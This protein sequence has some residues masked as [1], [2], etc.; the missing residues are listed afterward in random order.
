MPV[1]SAMLCPTPHKWKWSVD[2]PQG[3]APLRELDAPA[4]VS[5]Y[6]VGSLTPL[7]MGSPYPGSSSPQEGLDI[8]RLFLSLPGC[9]PCPVFISPFS[10]RPCL[11]ALLL[12]CP[13]SPAPQGGKE[14]LPPACL[15]NRPALLGLLRF[16]DLPFLRPG[17][18]PP[19]FFPDTAHLWHRHS[20]CK[21]SCQVW[22]TGGAW[23]VGRR[24]KGLQG[25]APCDR[26][27][28]A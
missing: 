19:L 3:R 23:G 8:F 22:G 16:R 26:G 9:P 24:A 15:T 14:L 25:C 27:A 17:G 4:S 11:P 6:S 20:T 21:C 2:L 13:G 7:L 28:S 12:R 18:L 5:A 1:L 10:G